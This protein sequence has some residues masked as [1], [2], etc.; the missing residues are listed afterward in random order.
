M[1]NIM[2][3]LANVYFFSYL[4]LI[5]TFYLYIKFFYKAI[6]PFNR[7]EGLILFFLIAVFHSATLQHFHYDLG[8]FDQIG[9]IAIILL[10][11]KLPNLSQIFQVI[12]ISITFLIL[13]LIHEAIFIMFG[14]LILGY[15]IFADNKIF[16]SNITKFLIFIFLGIA[17][18]LVSK[19]GLMKVIN[20]DTYFEILKI[21][22]GKIVDYGAILTLY[23][24]LSDNLKF[25]N[26]IGFSI[27]HHLMMLIVVGPIIFLLSILF[28]KYLHIARKLNVKTKYYFLMMSAFSPLLL[29]PIAVDRFRWISITITN[30]FIVIAILIKDN[31][32]KVELINTLEKYRLILFSTLIFSLI[33]GPLEDGLSFSNNPSFKFITRILGLDL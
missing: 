4:I 22:Y 13:I 25:A 31:N 29:Y 14:P 1:L 20:S 26:N 5:L 18:L 15:W 2:P 23:R 24:N 19:Y 21:E 12:I 27:G 6:E 16:R 11:I 33:L 9:L 28:F 3:S 32:F 17:T 10:I 7:E 30:L 8:R